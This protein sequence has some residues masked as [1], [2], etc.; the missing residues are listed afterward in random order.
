VGGFTV[1]SFSVLLLYKKARKTI[2]LGMFLQLNTARFSTAKYRKKNK[3][4]SKN[5]E[6]ERG[7][8]AL[9]CLIIMDGNSM[10]IIL[11]V[12]TLLS[13]ALLCEEAAAAAYVRPPARP[14]LMLFTGGK[15]SIQP[16]QVWNE[17]RN[18]PK[19]SISDS[20]CDDDDET[21]LS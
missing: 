7:C 8:L 5:L 6:A 4:T 2:S 19:V 21:I 15:K 18:V 13:M 10:V 20:S 14:N 17:T 1:A 3:K 12:T 9:A 16:D 11:L